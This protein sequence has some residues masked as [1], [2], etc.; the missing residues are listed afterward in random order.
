M[1]KATI[2]ISQLSEGFIYIYSNRVNQKKFTR[3]ASCEM[4]ITTPIFNTEMFIYQSKANLD[5]K[6]LFGKV[7]HQL[8][9][10]IK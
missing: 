3:L 6:I 7:I 2:N 5:E 10:Y 4:K 8:D 9:P 1:G